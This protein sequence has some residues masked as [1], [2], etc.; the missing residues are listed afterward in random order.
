MPNYV[1]CVVFNN[2]KGYSLL[3]ICIKLQIEKFKVQK[4]E[5]FDLKI[6][7]ELETL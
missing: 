6:C 4:K 5:Y 7:L 1:L 2:D 3:N